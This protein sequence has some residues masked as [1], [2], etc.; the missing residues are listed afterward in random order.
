MHLIAQLKEFTIFFKHIVNTFKN[1]I[2]IL[3]K[4]WTEVFF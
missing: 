1:V 4:K 2:N 3:F